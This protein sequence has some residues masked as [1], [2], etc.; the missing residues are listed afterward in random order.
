MEAQFVSNLMMTSQ[1]QRWAGADS[2]N[3]LFPYG[4]EKEFLSSLLKHK[5]LYFEFSKFEEA[6][7]VVTFE[8]AGLA[9]AMAQ[10]G[11]QRH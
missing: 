1:R 11:L 10:A 2:H 9:E 6:P 7:Q 8:V 5:K 3:S 4:R